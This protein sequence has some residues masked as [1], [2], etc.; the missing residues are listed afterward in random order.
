[1]PHQKTYKFDEGIILIFVPKKSAITFGEG[2]IHIQEEP[3]L[4]CYVD[5]IVVIT[6]QGLISVLPVSMA[7]IC[8]TQSKI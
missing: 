4:F 5:T 3:V 2:C 8:V 1:M 6:G 7:S